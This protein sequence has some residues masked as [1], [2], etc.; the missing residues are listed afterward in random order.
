[1]C[2]R[3]GVSTGCRPDES[4]QFA[5]KLG[6]TNRRQKLALSAFHLRC[7]CGRLWRRAYPCTCRS[8]SAISLHGA[9]P[10]SPACTS[11]QTTTGDRPARAEKRSLVAGARKD[12]ATAVSAH[13]L[14]HEPQSKWLLDST[15]VMPR[16]AEQI[17]TKERLHADN[18]RTG[19]LRLQ[20]STA[21]VF[22]RDRPGK[23]EQW[24][25]GSIR[26]S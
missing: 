24:L 6:T 8:G 10:P 14:T 21:R 2:L 11:L 4:A 15:S 26:E 25:A 17:R 12:A 5:E 23:A 9:T 22:R 3:G 18:A 19:Q 7:R 13:C 16:P 1:V 20:A